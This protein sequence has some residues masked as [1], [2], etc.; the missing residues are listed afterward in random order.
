MRSLVAGIQDSVSWPGTE[1][2]PPALGAQGTREVS[3]IFLLK[4]QL[5]TLFCHKTQHPIPRLPRMVF[6]GCATLASLYVHLACCPAAVWL[7]LRL[8]GLKST[9]TMP[10]ATIFFFLIVPETQDWVLT[11]LTLGRNRWQGSLPTYIDWMLVSHLSLP[12]KFICWNPTLQCNGIWKM[13]R[14][15]RWS[16]CEWG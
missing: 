9:R 15:W 6:F 4:S 10:S 5:K 1:L 2:R 14:S 7:H 3:G 12:P 8:P 16:P 13:V 11:L